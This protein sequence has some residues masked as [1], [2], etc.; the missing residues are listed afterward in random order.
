MKKHLRALENM[1][2][3]APINKFF[4]PKIKIYMGKSN[5]EMKVLKE[6]YH[7]AKSMHGS[8]YFKML[9]DAAFF[10][11]N[12]FEDTFFVVTTSFTT[13]ITRPVTNGIIYSKGKVVNKNNSQFICESILYNED[14]K[15]IARGSGMFIRSKILLKEALGYEKK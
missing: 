14:K 4:N 2:K 5:I 10:A 3:S 9:D 6:F 13:Y 1:Y 15:E 7:S 12:S 11:A 8:V